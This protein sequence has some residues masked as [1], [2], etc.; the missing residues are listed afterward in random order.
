MEQDALRPMGRNAIS[1]RPAQHRAGRLSWVPKSP[2]GR[3]FRIK[4]IFLADAGPVFRTTDN[5][6]FCSFFSDGPV[7]PYPVDPGRSLLLVSGEC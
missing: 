4:L 1:R 7:K 3:I 6:F 2:F 5:H